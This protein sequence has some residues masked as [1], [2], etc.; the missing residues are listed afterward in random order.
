RSRR[1]AG[2]SGA[3]GDPGRGR[4]GV[5]RARGASAG[6]QRRRGA[7][8]FRASA[9]AGLVQHSGRRSWPAL[10]LG[11]CAGAPVRAV[12]PCR[13]RRS[14]SLA[15]RASRSF[16]WPRRREAEL[17]ALGKAVRTGF[18]EDALVRNT[19]DRLELAP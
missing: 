10:V 11:G 14:D 12:T 17:T 15:P 6:A 5:R 18:P 19:R 13:L 9:G 1:G 7:L 2:R 4:G 8:V 3:G 16:P